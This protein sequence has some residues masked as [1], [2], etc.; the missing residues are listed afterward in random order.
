WD[1]PESQISIFQDQQPISIGHFIVT[2]ILSNHYEFPDPEL[3]E[4]ALGGNQVIDQPLVPP[5]KLLD[6]KMGGHYTLHITHPKGSIV[7]QGSAGYK[8]GTL[9]SLSADVLFMGIAGLGTQSEDYRQ[10]YF[11]QMLDIIDP[12]QVFLIHWDGFTAPIDGPLNS[13]CLLLEKYM[14]S[15]INVSFDAAI[16]AVTMRPDMNA[17]LLPRWKKVVLFE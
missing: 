12:Q 10:A 9:D 11:G 14:P 1:L 6:Y 2:P 8:N 7:I 15:K 13:E 3:R 5:V 16:E 4:K 17:H